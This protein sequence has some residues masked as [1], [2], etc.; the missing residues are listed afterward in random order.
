M[1]FYFYHLHPQ[2][3]VGILVRTERIQL[4]GIIVDVIEEWRVVIGQTGVPATGSITIIIS[5]ITSAI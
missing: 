5:G 3:N 4:L 1:P 2:E